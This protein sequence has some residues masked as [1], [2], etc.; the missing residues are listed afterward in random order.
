MAKK[1]YETEG[2]AFPAEFEVLVSCEW[3]KVQSTKQQSNS[4]IAVF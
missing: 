1:N 2:S 3:I 4:Q